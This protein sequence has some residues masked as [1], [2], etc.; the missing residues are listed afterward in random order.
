MIIL[1]TFQRLKNQ[2]VHFSAAT[3]PTVLTHGFEK[4]QMLS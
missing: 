2:W 3:D 4:P 1:V